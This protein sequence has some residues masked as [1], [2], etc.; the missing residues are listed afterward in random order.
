MPNDLAVHVVDDD[1]A[2]RDSLRWLMES[3]GLRVHTYD[4]AQGFLT[5]SYEVTAGC[6]LLD[7]RLRDMSGLELQRKL[8]ENGLRLPII[9]MTGYGDIMMA[10]QA[11]KDGATD[12]LTKP[13]D[14]QKLL[15]TVQQ[16]L[17]QAQITYE[18]HAQ[19]D[20]MASRLALLSPREQQVLDKVLDGKLNKV[21]ADELN[22]SM[23]TVET[24]R[25]RIMEKMQARNLAELVRQ[26]ALAG[27]DPQGKP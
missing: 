1:A 21:I 3:V 26:I 6:L 5:K 4:S 17:S 15:D 25:A 10:V 14:D 27:A 12:F 2:I 13:F 24:H 9:F 18:K 22:I 11:M 20:L 7:V 19:N 16:A 8:R 23:K